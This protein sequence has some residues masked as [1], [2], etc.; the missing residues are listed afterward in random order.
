MVRRELE[1]RIRLSGLRP[2]LRKGSRTIAK[3]FAGGH[4]DVERD[5]ATRFEEQAL[6]GPVRIRSLLVPLDGSFFAE[7]ALPLAAGIARRAG[8]ELRVV[9]VHVPPR[10]SDPVVRHY[11][12]DGPYGPSK[13][14]R[15]AYLDDV[16]RRL[17]RAST[18]TAT[19]HLYDNRDVTAALKSAA[20]DTDLVV[21][22][23]HGRGPLARFWHGSVAHDLMRHLRPPV[24]LVRGRKARPRLGVEPAVRRVLVPLDRT[25]GA[26]DVLEPAVALGTLL[27]ADYTLLR[28][29]PLRYPE[30]PD[31]AAYY[32]DGQPRPADTKRRRLA[33]DEL[34]RCAE[35]L[36]AFGLEVATR[37][38][39]DDRSPAS[40]ILD[41][42]RRH[43]VDLIAL[44]PRRRNVLTR[45]LF[46]STADRVIRGATVPILVSRP[47][48]K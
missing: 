18:V 24:L 23:T 33:N 22:A 36:R 4:P 31:L 47:D 29:L 15:F 27:G 17:A 16:T 43:P 12:P 30:S 41:F 8:A 9:H 38:V 34:A 48:A 3:G 5:R 25:A 2:S 45:L 21:M 35:R 37:V 32:P 10:L 40:A 19:P 14:S 26:E 7:H 28:T 46:G 42:A 44:T 13:S 1:H 11:Y 39:F 6:A 20:A